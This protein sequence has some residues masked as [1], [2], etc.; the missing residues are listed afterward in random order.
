MSFELRAAERCK[1]GEVMC[2]NS[3]L[4][5]VIPNPGLPG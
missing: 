2:S 3:D 4:F 5:F 1:I